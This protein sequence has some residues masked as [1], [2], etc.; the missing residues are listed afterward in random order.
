[1]FLRGRLVNVELMLVQECFW[2]L[3]VFISFFF[4][5]FVIEKLTLDRKF[6][7]CPVLREWVL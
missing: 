1:V 3:G 5:F 4:F 7:Y 6:V 2:F